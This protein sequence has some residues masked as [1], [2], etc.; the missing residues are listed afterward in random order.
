MHLEFTDINW[1]EKTLRI[2]AKAK[3]HFIPKMW[4]Q[5]DIPIPDNLFE[6]LFQ[7]KN[8]NSGQTLFLGTKNRTPNTHLLRALKRLVYRAGLNCGI[9][10][11]CHEQ[12]E[13]EEYTLHK[14]R[15]TYITTLLRNGVDLRTVQAYAGHKKIESTMRYLRPVAASEAHE[16]LNAVK[17]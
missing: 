7:W 11:S 13:C 15:R 8:A 4:E 5:R 10:D 9:C 3:W 12:H 2:Q 17:W 6:E 14:F 1:E 16:E